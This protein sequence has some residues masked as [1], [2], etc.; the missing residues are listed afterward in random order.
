[1]SKQ[2]KNT[3]SD[4]KTRSELVKKEAWF[5]LW[6]FGED[7]ARKHINL[8][9][10]ARNKPL[11]GNDSLEFWE[12]VKAVFDIIVAGKSDE[13]GECVHLLGFVNSMKPREKWVFP[14]INS[15]EFNDFRTR[16]LTIIEDYRDERMKR[17]N[18]ANDGS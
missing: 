3:L 14:L 10:K 8:N 2:K 18:T 5:L 7:K 13:I 6:R 12:E 1:M 11:T 15:I 9:L 16:L 4:P 17:K